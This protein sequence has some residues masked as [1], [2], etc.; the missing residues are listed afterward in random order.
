[1]KTITQEPLLLCNYKGFKIITAYQYNMQQMEKYE[2]RCKEWEPSKGGFPQI[3]FYFFYDEQGNH[4]ITGYVAVN[5]KCHLWGET[6]L[7]LKRR[8][9]KYII[10]GY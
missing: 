6:I 9:T 4:R 8:I 1:M 10:K 5:G 3:A 2:Q 7:G